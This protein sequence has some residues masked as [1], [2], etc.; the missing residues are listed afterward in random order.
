MLNNGQNLVSWFRDDPLPLITKDPAVIVGGKSL[1]REFLGTILEDSNGGNLTIAVPFI[2]PGLAVP[3]FWEAMNH[4]GIDLRL[5]VRGK[6]DAKEAA[7]FLR[8]FPWR[9]LQICRSPR[10][11]AKLYIFEKSSGGGS[12][13]VGSHNL[14]RSAA[15]TNHEAGVL[16]VTRQTGFYSS[17][18]TNVCEAARTIIAGAKIIFD[19]SRWLSGAVNSKG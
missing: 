15:E 5:V 7:H 16:I 1:L 3:D 17:I 9:S 12:V 4:A 2:G 19:S 18:I 14:S 13:L 8:G 11:H 10:L 6:K